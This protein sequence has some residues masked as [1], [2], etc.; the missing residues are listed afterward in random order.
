MGCGAFS[1][2][3]DSVG[4]RLS[5]ATWA[6][7]TSAPS[8]KQEADRIRSTEAVT[9]RDLETSKNRVRDHQRSIDEVAAQTPRSNPI[10]LIDAKELG[11]VVTR[12]S[13][14]CRTAIRTSQQDPVE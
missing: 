2:P 9:I 1:I 4:D 13:S 10:W 12:E 8:E 11:S 6:Q 5:L 7:Q 14:S 3:L